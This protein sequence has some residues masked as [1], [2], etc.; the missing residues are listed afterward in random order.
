MGF[1]DRGSQL[2]FCD[3]YCFSN[4]RICRY[5]WV[6]KGKNAYVPTHIKRESFSCIVT[7]SFERVIAFTIVRG[8]INSNAFIDHLHQVKDSV[9]SRTV[10]HGLFIYD[11]APCHTSKKTQQHLKSWGLASMQL[12]PY[13]PMLNLA[14]KLILVHKQ[15]T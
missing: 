7:H 11:G 5:G 9:S 3:E 12:S 2:L 14:E 6:K 13:S 1:V 15:K 8:T 10:R 4:Q